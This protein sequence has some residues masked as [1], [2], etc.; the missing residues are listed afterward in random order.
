MLFAYIPIACIVIGS[1]VTV[2]VTGHPVESR[3]SERQTAPPTSRQP[4]VP[5]NSIAAVADKLNWD[6]QKQGP[7]L[8]VAPDRLLPRSNNPMAGLFFGGFSEDDMPAGAKIP[9]M[10][11]PPLLPPPGSGGY[12]VDTLATAIKRKLVRIG[13]LSTIAPIDVLKSNNMADLMTG[14]I[15]EEMMA[16]GGKES[17]LLLL[18]VSLNASQW[19]QVTAETG[20][21][22]EGLTATQ[23]QMF[24]KLLPQMTEVYFPKGTGPGPRKEPDMAD[25][26]G[27]LANGTPLDAAT[28]RD[29]MGPALPQEQV[30]TLR[31]RIKRDLTVSTVQNERNDDTAGDAGLIES[32]TLAMPESEWDSESVWIKS[33]SQN[34]IEKSIGMFAKMATN[35][36]PA[37]PKQSDVD[38][39]ASPL[40]INISLQQ[41]KNLGDLV[42]RI[43][44]A[45]HVNIVCD[46]RYATLTVLTRGDMA[47]AGDILLAITRAIHGTLR[48]LGDGDERIFLLTDERIPASYRMAGQ[49]G[50]MMRSVGRMTGKQKTSV[51]NGRIARATLS[52]RNPL[53]SIRREPRGN[54]PE[55]LWQAAEAGN[56]T[57]T[58]PL[59]TLPEPYQKQAQ[60]DWSEQSKEI[61]GTRLAPDRVQAAMNVVAHLF[62]PATGA[63]TYL[64]SIDA[65]SLKPDANK[66]IIVEPIKWS[67][68]FQTRA[69][70]VIPPASAAEVSA[71]VDA[72][73]TRSI[74]HIFV[75][76]PIYGDITNLAAF[77]DT[78]LKASI[79]CVP[80]L[81]PLHGEN[82]NAA[83]P[84]DIALTGET[85]MSWAISK[86][87]RSL[88]A[89]MPFMSTTVENI[90]R[91]DYLIPETVDPSAVVS[92]M[93]VLST[94]PGI[95]WIAL[96][97]LAAPGYGTNTSIYNDNGT[98][99]GGG[100]LGA[101]VRFV[102]EQKIDPADLMQTYGFEDISMSEALID[103][104]SFNPFNLTSIWT[105]DLLKRRDTMV[106]RI[107]L[108]LQRAQLPIPVIQSQPRFIWQGWTGEIWTPQIDE[109][110]ESDGNSTDT[111]FRTSFQVGKKPKEA[112]INDVLTFVQPEQFFQRQGMEADVNDPHLLRPDEERVAAWIAERLSHTVDSTGDRP[113]RGRTGFVLDL[114]SASLTDAIM[115]MNR[116]I[117]PQTIASAD[118]KSEVKP[119]NLKTQPTTISPDVAAPNATQSSPV[120]NQKKQTTPK[121]KGNTPPKATP[122]RQPSTK[123]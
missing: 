22:K 58:V 88:I 4:K 67:P 40:Q 59:N 107:D 62:V 21:G 19:Q 93:K 113:V 100:T 37:I 99:I 32:I 118:E 25:L 16:E 2:P 27:R 96:H 56:D 77:A 85:S 8:I 24:E 48:K 18:L 90:R 15:M 63:F 112:K 52:A 71:L 60:K 10:L 115:F 43:A 119:S 12:R 38:Y 84:R 76:C 17:S 28:I 95:A 114:T 105:K 14:E 73:R 51:L 42:D 106:S 101:R 72:A 5:A 83:A 111:Q 69:I 46:R 104:R 47:N 94:L 54:L 82:S 81:R 68:S 98:W 122:K 34:I 120:I 103:Q 92:R 29:M 6:V 35:R 123:R 31:L 109:P 7:L 9:D 41:V 44:K 102:K 57:F 108:V 65:A 64:T 53:S 91:A 70:Y 36:I 3:I 26:L 89:S 61:Q 75:D 39:K 117:A 74:T 110:D 1:M 50:E 116:R 79:K 80:V 86:S 45:T 97:D 55:L 30:A 49:M 20:L 23:L 78:L 121:A 87:A 66:N 33:P 13:S 11:K